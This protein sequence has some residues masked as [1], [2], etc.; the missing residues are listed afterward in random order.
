MAVVTSKNLDAFNRAE[1]ERRDAGKSVQAP[2]VSNNPEKWDLKT[3]EGDNV[4]KRSDL[5]GG[6]K[7]YDIYH[8]THQDEDGP[9]GSFEAF[10]KNGEAAA[11]VFY[12]HDKDGTLKASMETN[13]AHRR[14]GLASIM[15]DK[16]EQKMDKKLTPD[17]PHSPYA[18]AFWKSREAGK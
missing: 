15:Y 4:K 12:A 10:H 7:E 5:V 9:S 8:Q 11:S 17:T 18:A 1:L 6:H 2:S 3:K 16:V 14:Q 13:P